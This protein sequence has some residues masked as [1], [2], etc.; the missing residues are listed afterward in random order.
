MKLMLNLRPLNLLMSHDS[1][2]VQ[3]VDINANA[4]SYAGATGLRDDHDTNFH[5]LVSEPVFDGVNISIP[6]KVV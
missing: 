3:A 4:T 6:R 2:I 5:P 1:P